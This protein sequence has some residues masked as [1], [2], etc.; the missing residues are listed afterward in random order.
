MNKKMTI[1]AVGAH[2]DDI[3]LGC[4]GSLAK[5]SAEGHRI[6]LYVATDSAYADPSGKPVRTAGQA[7]E[8]AKAAAAFLKARLIIGPFRCFELSCAEPLNASLVSL[9]G[10][11][12]PDRM[13]IPWE[14]DTHPDHR[15]LAQAAVHASRHVPTVLAYRSNWYLGP[16]QF[17]PRVF[18][19]IAQTIEEKVK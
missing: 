12:R 18:V 10:D 16:D 14:G 3:E 11:V 2:A 6:V 9:I 5:W 15:A 8:E 19:D 13:L 4:G 1:L 17:S 7:E